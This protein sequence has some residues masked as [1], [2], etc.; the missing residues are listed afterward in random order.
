MR[1]FRYRNFSFV[2]GRCTV[3]DRVRRLAHN[4]EGLVATFAY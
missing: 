4:E 3:S 1:P 2:R